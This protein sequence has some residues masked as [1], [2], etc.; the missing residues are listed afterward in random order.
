MDSIEYKIKVNK[1]SKSIYIELIVNGYVVD[2][3]FLKGEYYRICRYIPDKENTICGL[4]IGN[5]PSYYFKNGVTINGKVSND[6]I[7]TINIITDLLWKK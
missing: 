7:D 2:A 5:N 6:V 4:T 3:A 1:R